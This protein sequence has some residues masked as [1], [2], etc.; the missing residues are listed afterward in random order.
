LAAKYPNIYQGLFESFEERIPDSD[1]VNAGLLSLTQSLWGYL[2]EFTDPREERRPRQ[3]DRLVASSDLTAKLLEKMRTFPI[4]RRFHELKGRFYD[5]MVRHD[6]SVLV[7][8]D[9]FD[10]LR[11]EAAGN[12]FDAAQDSVQLIFSTLVTAIQQTRMDSGRAAGM[13]IKAFI[14]HDRFVNLSLRDSDKVSAYHSPIRW[15]PITLK[16][17]LD[18]RMR[19]SGNLSKSNFEQN[20]REIV[21]ET[22]MS[23]YHGIEE[24]SFDFILRHTCWRPRQMLIY[25]NRL[26]QKFDGEAVQPK[27]VPRVIAETSQE[28]AKYLVDE[29]CLNIPHLEKL[30][31]SLKGKS[32]VLTYAELRGHIHSFIGRDRGESSGYD[33]DDEMNAMYSACIFGIIEHIDDDAPLVEHYYPPVKSGKPYHVNFSYKEPEINVASSLKD[34]DMVVLHPCLVEYANLKVNPEIIVG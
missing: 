28:I 19:A 10:L 25:L 17:F 27:S 20:W 1:T 6:H 7:Q 3:H 2:D 23:P 26:A 13:R 31:R 30:I 22:V 11:T 24:N 21:P 5:L 34:E 15:N 9:G 33:M 14:P 16:D 4:D 29:Y 32:N 18:K 8:L 12:S